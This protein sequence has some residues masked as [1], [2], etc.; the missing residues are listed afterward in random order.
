MVNNSNITVILTHQTIFSTDV[1][2]MFKSLAN[3]FTPSLIF[4]GSRKNKP[5]KHSDYLSFIGFLTRNPKTKKAYE[6]I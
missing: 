4:Y 3:I 1:F 6:R 5:F 2:F